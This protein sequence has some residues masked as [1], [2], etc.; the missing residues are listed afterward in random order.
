MTGVLVQA[1][2]YQASATQAQI[3]TRWIGCGRFVWNQLVETADDIR[4][5]N[6]TSELRAKNGSVI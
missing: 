3:I 5:I 1:A 4:L 6:R 2:V